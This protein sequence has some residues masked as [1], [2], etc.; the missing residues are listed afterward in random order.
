M[1][2]MSFH[3]IIFPFI[4]EYLEKFNI[5][6]PLYTFVLGLL[7]LV[8]LIRSVKKLD[9]NENFL[10]ILFSEK[11]D[12]KFGGKILGNFNY[13]HQTIIY[14]SGVTFAFIIA[15]ILLIRDIWIYFDT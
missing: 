10:K 2:K 6:V 12:E 4:S 5:S 15:T 1:I 3:E 11:Y 13:R 14:I 8:Y 9:K 7:C